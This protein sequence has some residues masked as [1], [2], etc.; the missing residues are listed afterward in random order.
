L[1][2]RARYG[3]VWFQIDLPIDGDARTVLARFVDEAEEKPYRR[4]GWLITAQLEVRDTNAISED[5]FGVVEAY[6]LTGMQETLAI[7]EDLT[8]QPFFDAA[9]DY[10]TP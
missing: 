9:D 3:G 5:V 1:S 6:G 8:L 4:V 10:F 7:V 2:T